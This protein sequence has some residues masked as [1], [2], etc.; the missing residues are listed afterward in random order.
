MSSS[1]QKSRQPSHR[2]T[3]SSKSARSSASSTSFL[4]TVNELVT[5]DD[6]EVPGSVQQ[7]LDDYGRWRPPQV[8]Q[9][10]H[11]Q[12]PGHVYRWRNGD[13]SLANSYQWVT[14]SAGDP[15]Y[16]NGGIFRAQGQQPEY[17]R[18]V[19]MFYCN[20]FDHFFATPGDATVRDR[21]SSTENDWHPIVFDNTQQNISYV[22]LGGG[23]D[24][25]SV[26]RANWIDEVVPKAY[27]CVEDNAPEGG[28]LAGR[29][30]L[31]VALVAFS[32]RGANA[33]RQVL[34][35]DRAWRQYRWHRH[36]R[37]TGR[38]H[39]RGMVVTVFLDPDNEASTRQTLYE[40]EYG[41]P[42]IQ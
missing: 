12:I 3:S 19:T 15:P 28:G 14:Y 37:P 4:F 13:I 25:L 32:C 35:E 2:R 9:G 30:P 31:L 26:R 34:I 21:E 17:Y 38:Q 5:N 6:P 7:N 40:L 10:F 29:L 18:A 27:R 42:L 23:D 11:P 39:K 22:D 33:L 24:H 41:E 8:V 1:N 16:A 36:R 20:Q